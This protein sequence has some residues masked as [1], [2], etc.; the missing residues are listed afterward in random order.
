MSMSNVN[1]LSKKEDGGLVDSRLGSQKGIK[2]PSRIE[3]YVDNKLYPSIRTAAEETGLYRS[4]IKR[5]IDNNIEG[6]YYSNKEDSNLCH[7]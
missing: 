6:Y 4:T 5:R 1:R 7:P 2:S 3:V